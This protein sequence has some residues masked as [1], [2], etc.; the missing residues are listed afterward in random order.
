MIP[1]TTNYVTDGP[2]EEKPLAHGPD[3]ASPSYRGLNIINTRK[4]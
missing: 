4:Q 1:E 2:Y 3:L